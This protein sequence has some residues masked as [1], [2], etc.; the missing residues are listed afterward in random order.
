MT[1]TFFLKQHP[2]YIYTY[3]VSQDCLVHFFLF[4]RFSQVIN[5]QAGS[6]ASER[7]RTNGLA[8]TR[9][10]V[11]AVLIV[12]NCSFAFLRA[13]LGSGFMKRVA[14]VNLTITSNERVCRNKRARMK[15]FLHILSYFFVTLNNT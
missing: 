10:N 13:R 6:R 11:A 7:T 5:L 14:N 15:E 1:K 9:T 4:I 2:L 12:A 3:K 8:S